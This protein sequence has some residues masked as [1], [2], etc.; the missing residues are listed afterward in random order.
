MT[1]SNSLY[2]KRKKEV[3]KLKNNKVYDKKTVNFLNLLHAWK[4]R[5][6]SGATDFSTSKS[7]SFQ[8]EMKSD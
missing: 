7:S 3:D 6:K 1:V 2:D 5:Q 8:T 4:K